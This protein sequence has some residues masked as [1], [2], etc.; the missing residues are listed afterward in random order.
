MIWSQSTAWFQTIKLYLFYWTTGTDLIMIIFS[1]SIESFNFSLFH[2]KFLPD[3]FRFFASNHYLH[4]L[5]LFLHLFYLL[6]FYLFVFYLQNDPVLIIMIAII[7]THQLKSLKHEINKKALINEWSK[8]GQSLGIVW[9]PTPNHSPLRNL[10]SKPLT[11]DSGFRNKRS[12]I[13][14]CK[15]RSSSTPKLILLKTNEVCNDLLLVSQARHCQE[16]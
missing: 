9:P 12:E 5:N 10:A 13:L 15:W 3:L 1:A 2:T 7:I 14:P 6:C 8:F 4:F 11:S 16:C